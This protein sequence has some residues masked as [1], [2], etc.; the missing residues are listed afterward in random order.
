M[1]VLGINE[2]YH[3]LSAALVEDGRL[4]AVVEEE[5]LNRVKHT[6]GLCWGG[7]APERSIDHC[8]RQLGW[9]ASRLDAVA[10][11]YDMTGALSIKTIID[12]I[13]A[14][15]RR[16][17]L[18]DI[19][20]QRVRSGD[21]AASVIHGNLVGYFVHRR[22][23]LRALRRR[24]GRVLPVP[25][26]LAHASSAFR[27]SGF[28][29]A[30]ILVLDGLGEDHATSLFCGRGARI[31]GPFETYSQYQSLG[32]LYKTVTFLLGFGY[33]GDGRTMGL[34]AYG[35]VRPELEDLVDV[36]DGRYRIR[37]ERIRR[38]GRLARP[39]GL[40]APLTQDHKDVAA[41]IQALL[42]RAACALGENLHRRTGLRRLCLAGGVALNCNM[43][44][45]LL[46]LPFVD[47][48]FV[49]PGA[50]DMG[51]AVGA[52]LEASAWLGAVPP[53]QALEHVFYGPRFSEAE[54]EAAVRRHGLVP[55]R[56][57]REALLRR[58][59][60]L[61]A[62]RRVVGWFQGRMEFGPRAL[63]HRSILGAPDSTELRDRIN[64]LK[65]REAWRPLAPVILEQEAA[66]WLHD[67]RR[68]PFM[69]LTFR[70]RPEMALRVPGVVH[71]DGTAR[72]QT[73]SRP[74]HEDLHDLLVAFQGLTGLPMLLNTSLN[75]RQEPIVCSPEEA[76]E[77]YLATDMDALRLEHL[78]LEKAR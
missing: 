66:A 29:E 67:A 73:V 5:R 42:E 30:N 59:A 45:A 50:M 69:T 2:L 16:M 23:F 34:A 9:P 71:A 47:E 35:R 76:L 43:N 11:S 27:L 36:G 68:S 31:E 46:N 40:Q 64:R 6:P 13:V 32:M 48:L 56:L 25:H 41:T 77:T 26:H 78:L 20:N 10:L 37:L 7:A 3:D 49:Q 12:A 39:P 28:P 38:L 21:H 57:H 19:V 65:E 4:V 1:F 24:F 52:A 54:V 60:D 33:F 14:N 51:S 63:G 18:R 17:S 53:V 15:L 22:R 75:R 70:F 74:H 55:V 61:L 72:V 58:V 44:A 62:E 8:L